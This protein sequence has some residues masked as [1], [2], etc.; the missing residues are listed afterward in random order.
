MPLYDPVQVK[1]DPFEGSLDHLV[2]LAQKKE[3][4][5]NEIIISQITK[6]FIDHWGESEDTYETASDFILLIAQLIWLKSKSL[7]PPEQNE[8]D[9]LFVEDEKDFSIIHH[10]ID[11]SRFKQAAYNFSQIEN[12][13][14]AFFPR[15]VGAA[16][17]K[18]PLGIETIQLNELAS[19]FKDVIARAKIYTGT[20]EG[21]A[22]SVQDKIEWLSIHLKEK[23]TPF[24]TLFENASSKD[25]MI[26]IFLAL[27]ELI[28]MGALK[29]GRDD[30]QVMVYG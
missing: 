19:L 17:V 9:L 12:K 15:G 21:E 23:S 6:P 27:L 28:K 16:E 11:Y 3:V 29:V 13:Q 4:D 20:I 2:H 10:L 18:L 8:S 5:L 22:F 14:D 30:Q 1:L 26:V 25:E 24:I 7:L